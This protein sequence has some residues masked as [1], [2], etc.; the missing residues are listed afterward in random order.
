MDKA[1]VKEYKDQ[2]EYRFKDLD[3]EDRQ[4]V[5]G[6]FGDEDTTVDTYGMFGSTIHRRCTSTA[7]TA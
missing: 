3:D 4:R 6:L 7:N 1:L 2:S 5:Y